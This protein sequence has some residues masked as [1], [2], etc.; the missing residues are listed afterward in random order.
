ENN[1]IKVQCGVGRKDSLTFNDDDDG[2]YV[3]DMI[4][5]GKFAGTIIVDYDEAIKL[6][7][8][9]NDNLGQD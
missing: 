8:F 2:Y 7:D 3:V 4:Y 9:L 1:K 6:R 5:C